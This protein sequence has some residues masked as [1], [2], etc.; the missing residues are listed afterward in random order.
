[1]SCCAIIPRLRL[2]VV[3]VRGFEVASVCDVL[4]PLPDVSRPLVGA[5]RVAADPA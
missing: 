3:R 1:M 5:V 2:F 4:W